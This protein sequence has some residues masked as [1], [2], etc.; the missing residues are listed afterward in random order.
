VSCGGRPPQAVPIP[1]GTVVGPTGAT[2]TF[3]RLGLLVSYEMLLLHRDASVRKPLLR[4]CSATYESG[5]G[6]L[7]GG[8]D[9]SRL[10]VGEAFELPVGWPAE[11]DVE[12][13]PRAATR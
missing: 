2:G 1:A 10:G 13:T 3:A 4:Q 12:T 11:I 5:I 8:G 7:L 6:A 9:K